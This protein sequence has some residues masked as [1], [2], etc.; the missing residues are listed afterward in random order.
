MRFMLLIKS[1]A[2][3]EAGVTPNDERLSAFARFNETL[4]EAGVLVGAEGLMP[5]RRAA[6]VRAT[7]N[8]TQVIEG[9]FP[10]PTALI[11]GFWTIEVA[12]KSEAV[13][14]AQRVPGDAGEIEVRQV[15][16]TEDFPVDDSEQPG[17]WR[18]KEVRARERAKTATPPRLP[19]TKRFIL[20]IKSDRHQESGALPSPQALATMG[21]L[22]GDLGRSGKVLGGEGLRPSHLGARI[23]QSGSQRRV[24][25][26]PFTEAKEMIA[27]YMLVQVA[28]LE[29]TYDIARR[30][31]PVNLS[32]SGSPHAELEI[33]QLL[34]LEDLPLDPR[35]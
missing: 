12:S 30:W 31:L 27:G 2:D 16:E 21:E 8:E 24:L 17:G 22:M 9:P 10:E 13:A 20:M 26:G 15:Y 4:A 19:G 1:D 28:A 25:D 23:V 29:D 7:R 34:E 11:A 33:R 6:R 3:T 32:E 35:S 18:E 14:W 5:S